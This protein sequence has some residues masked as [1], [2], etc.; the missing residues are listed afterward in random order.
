MRILIHAVPKRLWYVEDFLVPALR[1]QGARDIALWV[2]EDHRGNLLSC[3]ESFQAMNGVGGTWHLQDDVL[4]ARDFVKRALE[5]RGGHVGVGFCSRLFHDDP[6]NAGL[7]YQPDMWHSFQ[8]VHIP[9]RLARECADWYFSGDWQEC[10]NENLPAM[11]QLNR[12]DDSLFREFLFCR[13]PGEVAYNF[14]P[15]LVEHVDWLTGG[16]TL[17]DW[18]G[19][20]PRSDRWEDEAL[21]N[22][23]REELRKKQTTPSEA[24]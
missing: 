2:D 23:L 21:V 22:E 15:N 13:H 4:P 6:N 19:Q 24:L 1:K 16:S 14:A 18:W 12:G 5:Y 9:N 11:V 20:A 7:V 10:Q 17:H 3:M 8:C